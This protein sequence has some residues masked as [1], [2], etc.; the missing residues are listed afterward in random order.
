MNILLTGGTGFIGSHTAVVLTEFGNNVV[1]YDNLSNSNINILDRLETITGKRLPFV[2]GDIR[3]TCKLEQ[4]IQS[5]DIDSV[6]HFAGLKA[7]G[8]SV[9][10]PI[11]Y[12]D[13]NIIGTLSLLKAMQSTNTKKLVFSSSAT[14]Y[15]APEY[16]PIDEGHPRSA[17]N[18][19][20]RSKL[21]IEDML[22]D[23]VASDP[24][25]KI[26]CLR[27]FNPIGA[28]ESGLIGDEPKGIP[29]N[30]M[31]YIVQVAK[32]TLPFLKVFGNDYDTIDGTGVRDYIHVMDLA[33]GHQ[34]ALK[35]LEKICSNN[36]DLFNFNLGTGKGYSVFEVINTFESVSGKA[37]P[38]QIYD[39]R[40][41]D[42]SS[43]YAKVEKA[44]LELSWKAK[45]NLEDMCKSSFSIKF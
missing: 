37:I 14:I 28:H 35:Y 45:L 17:V 21:H 6:I 15:G 16:L 32:G 39:R 38:Y 24:M 25:W 42:I 29:N 34:A 41:G 23:V 30:L 22:L 26:S 5:Y 31:P 40:K 18:P 20:G 33:R 2:N 19:Y 10:R 4:C 9:E 8:E 13:N 12:Y 3:D 11:H 7:V 44:N 27:Y 1:L 43:C 36:R